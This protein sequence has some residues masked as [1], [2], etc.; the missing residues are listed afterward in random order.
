MFSTASLGFLFESF[1]PFIESIL[2]WLAMFTKVRKVLSAA[3]RIPLKYQQNRNCFIK[4]VF[5]SFY[6]RKYEVQPKTL[7]LKLFSDFCH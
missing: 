5:P 3:D 4:H 6:L 7:K 1:N 2:S